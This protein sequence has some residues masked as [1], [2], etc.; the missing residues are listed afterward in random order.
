MSL[1]IEGSRSGFVHVRLDGKTRGKKY[2]L[3]KQGI[4]LKKSGSQTSATVSEDVVHHLACKNWLDKAE[5]LPQLAREVLKW[6]LRNPRMRRADK[7]PETKIYEVGYTFYE[8]E[9]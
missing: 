6:T 4:Y 9:G 5:L 2:N 1:I 7:I 8:T 3:A